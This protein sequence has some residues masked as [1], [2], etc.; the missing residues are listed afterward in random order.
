MAAT[1]RKKR[2]V[3]CVRDTGCEDLELHKVYECLPDNVAAR[4]GYVRVIDESR[5]DYLYP[6][7]YFGAVEIPKH[8]ERALARRVPMRAPSPRVQRPAL[9]RRR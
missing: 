6:T 3:L 8:A 4:E 5:E 2:F 1:R 9:A 7:A